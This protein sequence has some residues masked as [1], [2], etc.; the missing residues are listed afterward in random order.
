MP[1][2]AE[3]REGEGDKGRQGV[4]D[5]EREGGVAGAGVARDEGAVP[6]GGR[7]GEQGIIEFYCNDN[8]YNFCQCRWIFKMDFSNFNSLF[9]D[10]SQFRL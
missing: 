9:N 6:E 5:Q 3:V 2:A 10:R 4:R 7:G 1:E 8:Q